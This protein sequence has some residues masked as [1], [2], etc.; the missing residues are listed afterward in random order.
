[1]HPPG[2]LRRRAR[3]VARAARAQ[4]GARSPRVH[5]PRP[6]APVARGRPRRARRA[7]PR[8]SAPGSPPAAAPAPRPGSTRGIVTSSSRPL[9]SP[10]GS[11]GSLERSRSRRTSVSRTAPSASATPCN[12]SRS[13]PPQSGSS[14]S[15]N[16]R[17][18][19]RTRRVAT[20]AWWTASGSS[21][22]RTPAS[23][24]SSRTT[25]VASSRRTTSATVACSSSSATSTSGG[26]AARGPS[27][28]TSFGTLSRGPAPARSSRSIRISESVVI[29]L[30]VELDLQL[31]EPAR[32][33]ASVHHRD[34]IVGHHGQPPARVVAD[35]DA[36]ADG[37]QPSDGRQLLPT[38]VGADKV[39][40]GRRQLPRVVALE[41][42]L[43]ADEL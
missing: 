38:D 30:R 3:D 32:H 13:D 9:R 19:E 29:G 5:R 4:T 39:G 15:R 28:R 16:V 7:G 43:G 31:P 23:W 18:A 36:S 2:P 1:M 24:L 34:L 21:P 26:D 20:L 33:A 41:V 25:D 8:T 10:S 17:S 37:L 22:R 42:H 40:G 35:L 14:T 6:R 27:A 12:R 11:D